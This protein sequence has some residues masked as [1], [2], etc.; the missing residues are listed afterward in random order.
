MYDVIIAGAGPIGLYSAGLCKKAGL[1]FRILEEHGEVGKPN[2]C[3]GLISTNLGKLIEIRDDFIDHKAKGA[4]LHSNDRKVSLTKKNTAAYIINREKMDKALSKGIDIDFNT[5]LSDFTVRKDKVI[6]KTNRGE[7]EASILLAC[8][9][10]NSLVRRRLGLHPEENLTGIIAI[11][12]VRDVSDHVELF[13]DRDRLRDGFFWKIPR[14]TTTEYGMLGRNV[15]YSQLEGFFG[16]ENYEKMG[17][18]IAM[19]PVKSYHERIL[20]IGDAAAQ[21]K[22]WSGGGIVYGLK[23]ADIAVKTVREALEIGDFSEHYLSRYEKRWKKAVGK[24]IRYG[25]IFR[26]WY[27]KT[28]NRNINAVFYLMRMLPFLNKLDMDLL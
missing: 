25:M 1:S 12:K 14:G 8:D 15:K 26:R 18:P 17:G 13:F 7:L 3:S 9:G 22:P 11:E 24:Q 5:R 16:I 19:G 20:L 21:V 10:A 23:C 28:S 2:H 27:K 4:F 6:V